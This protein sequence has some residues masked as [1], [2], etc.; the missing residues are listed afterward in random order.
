[1]AAREFQQRGAD[2]CAGRGDDL[3][4][5]P[6]REREVAREAGL[7]VFAERLRQLDARGKP[8]G[9]DGRGGAARPADERL[10]MGARAD[11]DHEAR[12]ILPWLAV[13]PRS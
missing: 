13:A 5:E 9:L 1:M 7:R 12:G 2:G 10:G 8:R 3:R 11:G 4:T 6:P